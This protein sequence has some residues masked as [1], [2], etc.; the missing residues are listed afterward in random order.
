MNVHSDGAMKT[1][2]ITG[3]TSGIGRVTAL[4]L[5]KAG[6]RV[7]ATGRS[8]S[9]LDE[10]AREAAS[11]HLHTLQLD[12]T[13]REQLRDVVASVDA[14]TNGHGVDVLV[15]NAG[16]GIVAPSTELAESELRSQFETNVFG[17][18]AVTRAFVGAM[19][20]RGSGTII[21]VSS[22]G[23]RMTLP[24][25]GG[26]NATKYAVESLSDAMRRELHAFGVHVVLVEPGI[27]NTNFT[28]RSTADAERWTSSPY[29]GAF[30]RFEETVRQ[31]EKMGVPPDRIASVILRIVESRRP[32]ARYVAPFTG[33]LT[34]A[35]VAVLPTAWVDAVMRRIAR[36]RAADLRAL[37]A[38]DVPERATG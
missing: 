29:A 1:T 14:I 3:A 35:L 37:P 16:F 30:A 22:V 27:I 36:L 31:T 12:V 6:H 18:M 38:G 8:A 4:R 10:L 7:I 19:R 25:L 15:N 20:E 11:D 17:L 23:G 21:N 13:D 34:L 24:F 26:Y 9:A 2:L 33:R 32:R 28:P 5:A